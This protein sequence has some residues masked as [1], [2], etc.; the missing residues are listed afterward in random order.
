MLCSPQNHL[1]LV[2][3]IRHC[4]LLL[5]VGS[6]LFTTCSSQ[7]AA[8]TSQWVSTSATH[9]FTHSRISLQQGLVLYNQRYIK[10]FIFGISQNQDLK[11]VSC[12][13]TMKLLIHSFYFS[14]NSRTPSHLRTPTWTQDRE[15]SDDTDE[16]GIQQISAMH[17]IFHWLLHLYLQSAEQYCPSR[18]TY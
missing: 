3:L 8:V 16:L 18:Q 1:P 15:D 12:A 9:M 5:A 13:S 6:P 7:P 17:D 4:H 11:I 10:E 2:P 14:V